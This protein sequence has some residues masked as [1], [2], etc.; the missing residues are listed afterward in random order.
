[1]CICVKLFQ[2]QGLDAL[3]HK[4]PRYITSPSLTL[5]HSEIVLKCI[6]LYSN[7]IK[8]YKN[9]ITNSKHKC[10]NINQISKLIITLLHSYIMLKIPVE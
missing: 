9:A 10:K 5:K 4:N 6:S 2:L 8:K 3:S 7:I 1:M